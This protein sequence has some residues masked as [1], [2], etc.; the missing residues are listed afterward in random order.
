MN[1]NIHNI[2]SK[3][4]LKYLLNNWFIVSNQKWSHIQLKKGT[5]KVTIPNHW[6]KSLNIKTVIS[7]FKQ[8]NIDKLD[9]LWK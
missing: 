4:I 9:F 1:P 8:S 2:K 5:F 7:I 6:D 3:D